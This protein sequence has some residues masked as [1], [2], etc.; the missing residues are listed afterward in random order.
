M[1][2]LRR[3]DFAN[4]QQLARLAKT[5][6]MSP[7]EFRKRFEYVAEHEPPPLVLLHAPPAAGSV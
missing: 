2:R 7:E 4:P 6:D 1:I 3:D 5:I